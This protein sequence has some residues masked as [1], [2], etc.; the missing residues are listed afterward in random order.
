M[1]II[2]DHARGKK[3]AELLYNC[4][5]TTGI[6]GL[7]AMPECVMPDN[8]AKGSLDHILFITLTVSIDY[9]RDAD[10]LWESSKKT[11]ND[12]ET[13]YLF[14]PELLYKTPIEKIIK[15]MQK[16]KLSKKP[17]KDAAIWHTIGVTFYKKWGGDP[18]NLLESCNWDSLLILNRLQNDTHINNGKPVSDYP[19]LR[20]SKIGPLWLRML[21]DYAC[22][23]ELKNLESVPIPV[24]I[25]IARATLATGVVRGKE[26][27]RANELFEY[28]R[29]AWFESVKGLNINNRAMIPLDLDKP[30]WHLS[31]EG[32]SNRDKI[33]GY[34]PLYNKCEAREFCIRGAIKIENGFIELDT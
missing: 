5:T 32:C 23:T 26:K 21:R 4:F 18:R 3:L 16:H 14:N 17:E 11:F 31:R 20:G 33:T 29:N 9:Q 6:H 2:I 7:I 24:D 22:I 13:R 10:S 19:Y 34:C 12:P 30:L 28:I 27:I 15:D 8:I 1:P 25:H